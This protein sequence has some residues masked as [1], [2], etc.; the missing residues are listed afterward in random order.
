MK[1]RRNR[2]ISRFDVTEKAEVKGLNHRFV[3]RIIRQLVIFHLSW[4]TFKVTVVFFVVFF[5]GFVR[6]T[7][8]VKS[9][10]LKMPFKT[11]FALLIEL[12]QIQ[13]D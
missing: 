3:V 9:K 1:L 10:C 12:K 11:T 5:N 13:I 6:M 2:N 8:V 4:D 7:M